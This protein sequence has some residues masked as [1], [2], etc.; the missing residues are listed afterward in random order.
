MRDVSWMDVGTCAVGLALLGLWGCGDSGSGGAGGGADGGAGGG[1]SSSD[2]GLNDIVLTATELAPNTTLS[3]AFVYIGYKNCPSGLNCDDATIVLDNGAVQVDLG[4]FASFVS[5]DAAKLAEISAALTPGADIQLHW[6]LP[7]GSQGSYG[8]I[9]CPGDFS[10]TAPAA[11]MSFT[12]PG[13]L[14]VTWTAF[15]DVGPSGDPLDENNS[16]VSA[17]EWDDGLNLSYGVSASVQVDEAATSQALA[18]P[19]KISD[20]DRLIV[21]VVAAGAVVRDASGGEAACN[22]GR[23]VDI[24]LQ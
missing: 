20:S 8:P 5:W 6:T 3:P 22:I 21:Q 4:S 10:I 23:Q 19:A 24:P 2:F 11:G 9:R 7:D 17:E 13:N 14:D 16:S 18:L 1:S 15:S 12:T